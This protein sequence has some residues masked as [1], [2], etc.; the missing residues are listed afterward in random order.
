MNA[1][2]V[3]LATIL[4][5]VVLVGLGVGLIFAPLTLMW[6]ID[7]D[8]ST[9]LLVSW[10]AT[11]DVWLLGH[12]VPLLFTL[13][14]EL[15]DSLALGAL[16]REFVVDVALLGIG[17]LT[18]LWGYRLGRQE[19]TRAYPLLVWFLA[20]GT[21]VGLSFLMTFFLPEQV[22]QISLMDALVRPALFLAAGLAVAAWT[23]TG[24]EGTQQLESVVPGPAF[25]LV[26][27][28]FVAGAGAVLA[29]IGVAAIVVSILLVVSFA[30]V[31]TLYEALQPGI[32]GVL[33][34]SIGQLALLPTVIVWTA[35]WFVGP[36]FTLG[37]G[38]LVSPL[39]TNIQALPTV[40]LL[41]IVPET[42]PGFAV[43]ALLVP[44]VAAFAAGV[45]I[46]TSVVPDTS[47]G[48]WKS[49]TDTGF[50]DQP[51]IRCVSASVVAGLVAAGLGGVLASLTSGS[52]GPGRFAHVGP[53]PFAVALWWGL[54][55]GIGVLIGVLA[56]G[57]TK[58]SAV[59]S[60]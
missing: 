56:A 16:S 36:G 6:A 30:Q 41:G 17:L 59:A 38:A 14:P 50:F 21:L 47:G 48:L 34:I 4:Q 15:A 22:V 2:I 53:D 24:H 49:V 60:R 27:S 5:I 37:A 31:I 39:G 32:I 25:V 58:T 33:V 55:V 26:R 28:G 43:I 46:A 52:L 44:V 10:A 35:T 57:V 13:S 45:A 40:P 20:V 29:V 9:D 19:A 51:V 1:R 3:A 12:G 11:V 23:G 8:F 42:V 54:E 18:L 7:D